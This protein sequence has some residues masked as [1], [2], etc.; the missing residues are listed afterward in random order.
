[1]TSTDSD[2]DA[3]TPREEVVPSLSST[4]V[5]NPPCHAC[6]DPGYR[7]VDEGDGAAETWECR[8]CFL[9]E[10]QTCEHCEEAAKLGKAAVCGCEK[11][12]PP[13]K[14]MKLYVPTPPSTPC[15]YMKDVDED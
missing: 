6:G 14:K 5:K 10:P 2:S 3:T 9:F 15:S 4:R 13:K 11:V 12:K 1:M 7:Q 8:D